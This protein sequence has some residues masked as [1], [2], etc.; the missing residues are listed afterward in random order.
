[1][2]IQKSPAGKIQRD[3]LHKPRY[4]PSLTGP[5]RWFDRFMM[6]KSRLSSIIE[7]S[8]FRTCFGLS[9]KLEMLNACRTRVTTNT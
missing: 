9:T 5:V 6:V 3:Q 7:F 4:T 8:S 2:A 1:M